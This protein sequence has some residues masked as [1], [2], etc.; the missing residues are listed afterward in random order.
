MEWHRLKKVAADAS[1][2]LVTVGAVSLGTSV[3]KIGTQH[4]YH[5]R[6]DIHDLLKGS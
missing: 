3:T 1:I 2:S 4:N 6:I 5:Q